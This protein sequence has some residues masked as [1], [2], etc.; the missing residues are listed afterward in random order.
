MSLPCNWS[1]SFSPEI[2]ENLDLDSLSFS[3]TIQILLDLQDKKRIK[4]DRGMV[5]GLVQYLESDRLFK[6]ALGQ[7]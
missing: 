7:I 3:P 4:D 5:P 2:C 6:E 1:P